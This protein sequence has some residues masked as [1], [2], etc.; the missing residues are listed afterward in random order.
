MGLAA[1]NVARGMR[2]RQEDIENRIGSYFFF[3]L[4][5]IKIDVDLMKPRFLQ[6]GASQEQLS[7]VTTIINS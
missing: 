6:A 4:F 1:M 2:I 3:V 5:V 7:P